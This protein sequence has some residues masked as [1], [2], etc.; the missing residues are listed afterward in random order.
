MT[1]FDAELAGLVV[2]IESL[3]KRALVALFWAC[4]GA[5]LP[6]FRAWASYR[7]D[8][9]ERLLELAISAAREFAA[10]GT[11]PLEAADLLA[12]LEAST[13]A[14]VSSTSAQDCWI[15]ADVGIRVLVD[16]GYDAAPAIEY[17]LEPV[18]SAATE[19]LYGV[20]QLGTSDDEEE[21]V[22]ALMEHHK[23]MAALEFCRW[24]TGFLRARLSPTED[25]LQKLSSRAS[26]LA[27]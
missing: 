8:Q 1:P 18:V 15:C 14:G 19:E 5:L 17:A 25:D 27:P 26:V 11:E 22:R 6:E 3:H 10:H 16:Q 2:K 7:G 24:A 23:V 9:R 4:S 12:A 20:S 13:P 21:Q